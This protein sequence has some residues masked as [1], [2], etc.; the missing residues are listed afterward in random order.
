[1]F[2]KTPKLTLENEVL[3]LASTIGGESVSVFELTSGFIKSSHGFVRNTCLI[4]KI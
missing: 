3:V 2:I 4:G 1:M